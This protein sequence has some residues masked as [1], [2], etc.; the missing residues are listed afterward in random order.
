[1]SDGQAAAT[2]WR[3]SERGRYV[4]VAPWGALL[5][6]ERRRAEAGEPGGWFLFGE[7]PSGGVIGGEW[8]GSRLP[9][10]LTTATAWVGARVE[11]R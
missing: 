3:R 8:M 7:L 2:R 5:E 1:M 10:A 11:Q 6:I 9:D 4:G